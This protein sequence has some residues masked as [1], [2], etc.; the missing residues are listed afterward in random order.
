M[1]QLVQSN[2]PLFDSALAKIQIYTFGTL[3][4]VRGRTAVTESD[5]HT[6]QARQLLKI[7]VTERPRPVSTDLLIEL[8]WPNS[9]PG[10]AATTLRS[11]INA[12]RNVLEPERPNRAPSKY[13]VT[14]APGY[15]F[16]LTADIWLDAEDFERRMNQAQMTNDQEQ[17][18]NLLESALDLYKDDYLISDP[19]ADWLQTERERLRER[20]FNAL[21]QT[22][23]LYAAQGRYPDA[24]MVTRRLLARDEVRENA[25]QSLMRYQAES[26]DSAGALLT[27]ERCRT[28]L[29]DELGADPSPMTQ[30]LHQRILN[31]EIEPHVTTSLSITSSVAHVET[32]PS[33]GRLAA[34][35]RLP[36]RALL[37]VL[38]LELV[39]AFIGREKEAQLIDERLQKGLASRGSLLAI[40]GE[41]G[42]GKTRL[43]YHVLKRAAEQDITVIS[44]SCQVL[45]Q[46]LPFAPLAD[47]L[48]RYLYGLP[49]AVIRG[50]PAANLAHL[51]QIMPSLQDHMPIMPLALPDLA[52]T[53]EEN[54]LRLID[55]I[56]AFLVTL[57]GMRP[58][59]LFLDD[60][61]WADADTLAVLGRLTQRLS[62]TALFVLL[63]YRNEE[64]PDNDALVT[65]V[66]FLARNY[67]QSQLHLER[68]NLA[69]V[70]ACVRVQAPELH[71][72]GEVARLAD[73]L[74]RTTNGN[75]LFVT[76]V[77]RDLE[78]RRTAAG[79]G[80]PASD[81]PQSN[82]HSL[83]LP[84][85]WRAPLRI[86]E[87][88]LDRINRL[89]E[90]ARAILDLCA[91]I[92][93]DFSLDLLERAAAQ[94]P[95]DALGLLL[96]RRFLLERPD[97]RL[98]FGHQ[99]VRQTVY[100]HL[101]NLQRRR[102][103][104]NVAEALVDLGQADQNPGETAL[105]Y[106]QSGTSY[107]LL[108]AK[109]NVRA[110]E[111]RLRAYGFRQAVDAFD[112][113]LDTLALLT[114]A[115]QEYVVRALQGKG[116]AYE[117]LFDP[118]GVTSTYRQLQEWST[119]HDDRTLLLAT[120]T[121]LTTMLGLL[122]QQSESNQLLR[123]LLQALTR[124]GE[125]AK[126]P[127]VLR[128]LLNRRER[129]YSLDDEDASDAWQ[130]YRQPAPA[131]ANPVEDI[132]HL[133]EPVHAVLPLFDYGWVLLVQGQIGEATR[134]LEAVVDL[135]TATGQPSITS[136]AYHQLAVTARILGDLEQSQQFNDKS[137][138]INRAVAGTAAELASMWP[139]I[140]S[141][142]LSLR[143]GHLDDAER[144]L[145]RV[146]D[147]LDDRPF[148]NN[149]R[150][151]ANIGLG[152]VALARGDTHSARGAL[153]AALTDPIHLY[154]YTH[155]QALLGLARIAQ[156]DGETTGAE[157]LLRHA[158]RFAGRRS[159]LEE[160]ITVIEV[161]V[162]LQIAAA[163]VPVLVESVLKYVS[164]IELASAVTA[165]N[166]ALE[167]WVA[168]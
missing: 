42:V 7:L 47:A 38:D 71:D 65:F 30:A 135:A 89:P 29:S 103:H 23:D 69:Q 79:G 158:L 124:D 11:A 27:Y 154:P 31:G 117:A 77:M 159:L 9:T 152:L 126:A 164:A 150:N 167:R 45:E 110:G 118:A 97:D 113:A 123:E 63:A 94:D 146:V 143:A 132:L 3:Q 1:V 162:D 59:V 141:G 12:L 120:Y 156:I 85:S 128:D 99:L 160:Y 134:V 166:R 102:L 88:I 48:G 49:D 101:N 109:Y 51:A 145:R 55:S 157:Q 148:F 28:V 53:T 19:Y 4:V 62:D 138:A 127:L 151:S 8:L 76:E 142:F 165:L 92:G 95:L 130:L 153:A 105:H 83:I 121:R 15:A 17:R 106:G 136:N 32:I 104:L 80:A 21:L 14:Q 56:A 139:R 168:L 40:D 74:Y 111:K 37:P 81:L 75:P 39:P 115:P 108:A 18:L 140:S 137:I 68:F 133:F 125:P 16:H 67:P 131:V 25:Y 6:R 70:E 100:D 52:A 122:G 61:Q 149:Y 78:E 54:R 66:H 24:I 72:A 22:A 36:Q 60:L 35:A 50:F 82:E 87:I 98:D 46:E 93:R 96:Q 43:A 114:D 57:S 26:G 90:N 163:P 91:V 13:I 41:A 107:R 144:R 5:W 64:L 112:R 44:G 2:A 86:Q 129:I 119:R 33:E 73:F 10:A 34:P 155:V 58:L 161:I 116:L 84:G 20:F 147:F